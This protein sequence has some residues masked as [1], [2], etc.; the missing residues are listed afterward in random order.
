MLTRA[1]A[2]GLSRLSYPLATTVLWR[3]CAAL[4]FTSAPRAYA[5]VLL[6]VLVAERL[7][8]VVVAIFTD[9]HMILAQCRH[10]RGM[11]D[12]KHLSMRSKIAQDPSN[13]IRCCAA[14]AD[15]GFIQYEAG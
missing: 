14:D 12:T 8:V 7:D 3:N 2:V 9:P 6:C 4:V 1:N 13:G 10:L 11:G 5:P 15:I